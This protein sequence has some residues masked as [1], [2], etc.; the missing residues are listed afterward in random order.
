M[1]WLLSLATAASM[2]FFLQLFYQIMSDIK[3]RRYSSLIYLCYNLSV[4]ILRSTNG[5]DLAFGLST[6]VGLEEGNDFIDLSST[7]TNGKN[8]NKFYFN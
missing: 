4:A 2:F 3:A 1:K 5:E 7:N 8:F 6:R